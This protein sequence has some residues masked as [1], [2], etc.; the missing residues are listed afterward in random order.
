MLKYIFKK[1]IVYLKIFGQHRSKKFKV[2]HPRQFMEVENHEK[3]KSL[4]F[5]EIRP[6][7][8]KTDRGSPLPFPRSAFPENRS[9]VR[10]GPAHHALSLTAGTVGPIGLPMV[11]DS[12]AVQVLPSPA[13]SPPLL[14]WDFK[15]HHQ[16]CC[17]LLAY[18]L[19]FDDLS[20]NSTNLSTKSID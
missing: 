6:I 20:V 11:S 15:P 4:D 9:D 16:A 2:L 19:I 3:R 5:L 10:R 14:A 12:D 13:S 8:L 1:T 17:H 18:V 7:F